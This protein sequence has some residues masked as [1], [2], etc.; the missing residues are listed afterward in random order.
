MGNRPEEAFSQR[1][2]T[3]T[4][5]Y[6]KV[7]NTSSQQKAQIKTTVRYYYLTPVRMAIIK[8]TREDGWK[9]RGYRVVRTLVSCLWVC[10]IKQPLWK[11]VWRFL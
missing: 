8:K 10:K 2:H 11:I 1:R 5:K 4:T 9:W 3:T 6:K 7:F